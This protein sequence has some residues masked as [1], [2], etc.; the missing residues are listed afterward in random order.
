LDHPI[1]VCE[2]QSKIE[3]L[4]F[5]LISAHWKKEKILSVVL[6][7][8]CLAGAAFFYANPGES[9]RV[10]E[11]TRTQ[12][13]IQTTTRTETLTTILAST[14]SSVETKTSTFF[15][16]EMQTFTITSMVY[17]GPVPRLT[18]ITTVVA[19]PIIIYS[20]YY[21]TISTT[22]LSTGV[23][24]NLSTLRSTRLLPETLTT[25][26]TA[27]NEPNISL[28]GA[29]TIIGLAGVIVPLISAHWKKEKIYDKEEKPPPKE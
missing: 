25:T 20:V 23:L 15:R 5:V 12:T 21:S 16:F 14:S 26:T 18:V 10:F 7:S 22:I 4:S 13:S 3:K 11:V 1:S 29:L 8:V 28:I 9:A 19:S 17:T 24:T 6:A 2:S 27:R